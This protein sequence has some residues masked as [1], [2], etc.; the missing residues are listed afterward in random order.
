MGVKPSPAPLGASGTTIG[1]PALLEAGAPLRLHRGERASSFSTVFQLF[2]R[3]A[4][5]CF[6]G[7]A[8]QKAERPEDS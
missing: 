5:C 3:I 6:G 1:L 8:L 4:L 7:F 2:F